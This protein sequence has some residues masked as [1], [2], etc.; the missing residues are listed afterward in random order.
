MQKCCRE[1]FPEVYRSAVHHLFR[2]ELLTVCDL[3][4]HSPVQPTQRTP[5][6]ACPANCGGGGGILIVHRIPLFPFIDPP[7]ISNPMLS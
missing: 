6:L 5:S 3:H 1:G 7:S 4:L 2:W